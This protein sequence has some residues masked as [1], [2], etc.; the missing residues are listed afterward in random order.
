MSHSASDCFYTLSHAVMPKSILII[1]HWCTKR[2]TLA[3]TCTQQPQGITQPLK[4]TGT[5]SC[6]SNC[7]WWCRVLQGCQDVGLTKLR[8]YTSVCLF[9]FALPLNEKHW[10]SMLTWQAAGTRASPLGPCIPG[11]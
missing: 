9:I 5:Q 1:M 3:N 10:Q 11:Q 6:T 4:K 8:D 2:T 7:G